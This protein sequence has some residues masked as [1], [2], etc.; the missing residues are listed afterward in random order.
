M[1]TPNR[2]VAG[3]SFYNYDMYGGLRPGGL[4][5]FFSSEFVGLVAATFTSAFVYIGVRY[6]LLL[7]VSSKLQLSEDQTEAMDRLVEIPAALA[8]FVG[9]YADA[10]PLW[11]SRRKSYMVLGM[12]FSLL[13]LALIGLGCL[14]AEDLDSAMGNSFSYIMMLLMGGVSFG[15]MINFCSVHTAVVTLSQRESLERRGVFQADYLVVRATGQI[16]ARLLVYLIQNVVEKVEIS[17]I[18]LALMPLSVTTIAVVIG[19]LDE[20]PAY[21]KESLRCKCESYWKLTKQKAVWKILVV[22]ASFAFFLNFAFPLVTSALRQWTDT[23]DSASA[24]LS[25]SLNDLVMILTVLLWRWQLRN[26]LWRRLFALAPTMTITPQIMMAILVIPALYRSSAVYILLTGLGGVSSGVMALALLVPVAEIIEESSEGGVV[27]LALSFNTIFKVFAST[28]L[29]T[30]QR[31]SYF[32]SSDEEDTTHRRWSIAILELVTCCVNSFAFAVIPILPL[33]KLD[34][35]L[36]RMYGGFTD[37]ASAL[38]AA[39][40][41]TSLAYCV[42]YNIYIFS[43]AIN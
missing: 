35:Q 27:G 22:I 21:R 39:A 10:V 34:A 42:A 15:S 29:T 12:A 5:R 41:L 11:G 33:Q 32:P 3:P 40:F 6:G 23:T 16:S 8:F 19:G 30:I 20:P 9:L 43:V 36:V 4:V 28:L 1:A 2:F 17:L 38:T 18:L 26:M 31:A 37:S 13:C 7:M 14:F 24:L 25:S